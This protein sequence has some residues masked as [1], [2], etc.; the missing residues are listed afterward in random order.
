MHILVTGGAGFLGQLLAQKLLTHPIIGKQLQQLTLADVTAVPTAALQALKTASTEAKVVAVKSDLTDPVAVQQLITSDITAVYHLAAVVSGQAEANFDLGKAV[1]VDGTRL[2]LEAV[3]HQAPGTMVVFA[4]SL[5]VFGGNLPEVI[6]E[7]TALKPQSS[8]G[9]Q[10]AIGELWVNDYTRKGYIDGR[11]LRLPTVCV[12][13]GK[14]NAATSSFASSIIREPL[15][16]KSAVCPVETSL[17]LWLSSPETVVANLIHSLGLSAYQ[18]NDSRTV[19]LPGITVTVQA[20]IEALAKVGG[21]EAA[22]RIDYQP[23]ET[24]SRIV[25]SWPSRFDVRRAIALGFVG[26]LAFTD[27]IAAFMQSHPTP[28]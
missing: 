3:R 15:Q 11:V 19:N 17:P 28:K 1:N 7:A 14:P 20:M 8:Y 22:A 6:T 4:S 26:D 12:R 24:I 18:F 27:I 2:L 5:A 23:D 13:P 10:K 9:T 16:G 21:P 25:A